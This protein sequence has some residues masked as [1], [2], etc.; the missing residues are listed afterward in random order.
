MARQVAGENTC[1]AGS[2]LLLFSP[3]AKYIKPKKGC[4]FIATLLKHIERLTVL[5]FAVVQIGHISS[6]QCNVVHF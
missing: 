1:N 6:R 3:M 4:S 2:P 5:L